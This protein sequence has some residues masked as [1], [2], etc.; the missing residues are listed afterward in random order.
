MD[1]N[2]IG[3][4]RD[5]AMAPKI[6]IPPI[7]IPERENSQDSDSSDDS[8]FVDTFCRFIDGHPMP[9]G[10]WVAVSYT[11]LTLPTILRV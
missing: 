4:T 5:I 2:P 3:D 1:C 11:H 7:E 8:E 10:G 6:A 9:P